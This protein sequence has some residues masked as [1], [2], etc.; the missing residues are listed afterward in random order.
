MLSNILDQLIE[1][2]RNEETIQVYN[3]FNELNIL[4]EVGLS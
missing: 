4:H 2:D 3:N 1:N